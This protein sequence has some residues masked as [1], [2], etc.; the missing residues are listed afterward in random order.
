MPDPLDVTP[1]HDLAVIGAGVNGLGIAQDA[2]LRSLDVVLVE[3]DDICSG[4]SA[5]SGRLIHGGLRYLEHRDFGLVRESL[6]ERERLFRLAP[7]LVQ[8]VPLMMPLYRHNRRP[9]WLVRVGMIAYDILSF[10]KSPPRHR[11]LSRRE[12]LERFPGLSLDGLT[13][14]ALFYEGQVELAERLCVELAVDARQ[15]GADIRTH[16][17]VDG[18][19]TGTPPAFQCTNTLTGGREQIRARVVLNVAGPWIDGVLRAD[20]V[21]TQPRLNGGT[22][23]SHVVVDPFPGAPRDIVYY[24]SRRD[25]RL[26]LVIP[27]LGR[28]LIGTTDIRFE[29]DPAD[30]RCDIGEAEYLLEEVNQLIPQA[31]LG[32]GDVLFTYS[33]VRPLPYKPDSTESSVPRSHVLFDHDPDGLPGWVTVVGGKLTTYRQLAEEA[34]DL[35]F[36]RLDRKAPPCPTR[37]RPLPGSGDGDPS[38]LADRLA[39]STGMPRRTAGRLARL[40]GVRAE[41]VWRLTAADAALAE[42]LDQGSGL[43]GA[44]VLFALQHELAVT[45]TDVLARRVLV[46]F[47]RD[48]G[49]GSLEQIAT[50]AAT[51]AGWSDERRQQEIAAYRRWLDHL[52]VPD[53]SGPRSV[54]FGAEPARAGR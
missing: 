43:I 50:M 22:K 38:G 52:A 14:A 40:Y 16:L 53:A 51:C 49:L 36:Q 29:D 2:A 47:E 37:D 26:V 9:A 45:L 28:Y 4:V 30:A 25:G 31:N 23:G 21:P 24:E 8:S 6:L 12:T 5:W 39:G 32:L 15:A 1:I 33:G 34:V 3:Q 44:E 54:S 11:I 48:H 10:K 19:L 42:V 13:G 17:R 41:E 46:A 27:W 35:V 18:P 7:H 20:G